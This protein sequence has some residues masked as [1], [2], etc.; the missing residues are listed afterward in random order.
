MHLQSINFEE[1]HSIFLY[2]VTPQHQSS[3]LR[4]QNNWLFYLK[5]NGEVN[6]L[7]L[8]FLKGTKRG[9]KMAT[10]K[11]VCQNANF[12]LWENKC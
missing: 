3:I 5:I 12:R 1:M 8:F 6:E 4:R 11:V 2:C 10:T 9:Q 7:T